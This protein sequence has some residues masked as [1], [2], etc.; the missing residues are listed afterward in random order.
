MNKLNQHENYL[1]KKVFFTETKWP[2]FNLLFNDI[3][4]LSK[5]IKTDS[6]VVSLE[7]NNLYGGASLFA[8]FFSNHKFISVDCVSPALKKRGKY[9]SKNILGN[10]KIIHHKR[11]YQFDYRKIKLKSNYADLIIIPNLMHHIND[12]NILLNQAK[13]ILKKKGRIYI[14]EPMVRELHQIPED[15][16]RITPYGFKFLLKKR[17]FKNFKIKFEGGPFTAIIYCW[18][19]SLQYLPKNLVTKKLKWLKKNTKYLRHLD[20]KYR[21]NLHRKKTSFPMSYSLLANL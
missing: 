16:Y 6:C 9:N 17:K 5:L 1:K 14:F 18:D 4:K 19:Q 3:K 21:K 15:Y 8:P 10:K 11:N 13:R 20:K 7:R 12:V 2:H